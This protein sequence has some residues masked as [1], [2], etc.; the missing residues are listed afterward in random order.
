MIWI[1]V[2]ANKW[3][4]PVYPLAYGILNSPSLIN[5]DLNSKRWYYDDIDTN[6]WYTNTFII[7]DIQLFPNDDFLILFMSIITNSGIV[8]QLNNTKAIFLSR[9]DHITGKI[10]WAKLYEVN[11][12]NLFVINSMV[13]KNQNIWYYFQQV[14]IVIHFYNIHREIFY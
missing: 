1:A 3:R 13:I 14:I 6:I 10:I 4:Q 7:T 2:N 8:T 12:D 11:S 9:V 5:L